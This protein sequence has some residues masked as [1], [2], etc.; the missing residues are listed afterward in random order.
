M[1]NGQRTR[2][3]AHSEC[4]HTSTHTFI[5]ANSISHPPTDCTGRIIGSETRVNSAEYPGDRLQAARGRGGWMRLLLQPSALLN[6]VDTGRGTFYARG[7]RTFAVCIHPGL[8]LGNG[9]A[10]LYRPAAN[11]SLL[12]PASVGRNGSK[13]FLGRCVEKLKVRRMKARKKRMLL[14]G[15]GAESKIVTPALT[16]GFALLPF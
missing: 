10:T 16:R 1:L 7:R 6:R 5:Q 15:A 4:T 8:L 13:L 11:L 3:S 14:K 12:R 9:L 2:H